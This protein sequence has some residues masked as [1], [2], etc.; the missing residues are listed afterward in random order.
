MRSIKKSKKGFSLEF[1]E[2]IKPKTIVKTATGTKGLINIQKF[3]N[4]VLVV[5]SSFVF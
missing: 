1:C 3:P 5:R 2:K 4:I